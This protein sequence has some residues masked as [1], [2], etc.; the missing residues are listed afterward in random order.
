MNVSPFG[1]GGSEA[2]TADENSGDGS[3]STSEGVDINAILNALVRTIVLREGGFAQAGTDGYYNILQS[4]VGLDLMLPSNLVGNIV[5]LIVGNGEEYSFDDF[6]LN[7]EQSR[8]SLVLG[9]GNIAIEVAAQSDTGF[10][11]A[12]STEAGITIDVATQDDTLLSSRERSTYVDMTDLVLNIIDLVNGETTDG[13]G[14]GSQRVTFSLSGMAQFESDGEG[15][16]DLGS[17]LADYLGDIILELNTQEAFSDG[18]AF[19]LSVAAD[20]GAIDFA[21]LTGDTPDWDAFLENTDLDTIEVALELLNIDDAGNIEQD[22][23]LGGIYISRGDCILTAP[24]SSTWS[25]IIPM[26]PTSCSSSSKPHGSARLRTLRRA[27]AAARLLR[28]LPR[29]SRHPRAALR[30]VTRFSNSS[31]PTPQCRL[32]S[33]RALSARCL[34]RSYPTSAALPTSSTTST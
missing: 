3:D 2:V 6:I 8:V 12:V 19:R 24:T 31:I 25:R 28:R 1:E 34:P 20:L 32:C 10:S 21:S 7:E 23:V 17:L 30:R 29:R 15:S 16:Y 27:K 4:G 22:N 13:G 18:I 9:G 14:F 5:S 11:I 26:C 33:P